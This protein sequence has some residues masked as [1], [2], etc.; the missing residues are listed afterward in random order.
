MITHIETDFIPGAAP[1]LLFDG[2]SPS[3]VALEAGVS[4]GEADAMIAAAW[5][6]VEAFTGRAYRPITAG[7]VIIRVSSPIAY[8]WPRHPFPEALTIEVLSNGTWVP[9]WETYVPAA[10]LVELEIYTL[11]RLTQVGTVT[12]PAP[13][14]HVFQAVINLALYQLIH[15]PA[16]REF[17]AQSAGDS[18]FTREALMGVMYGSGA[19]ALLASEMRL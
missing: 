11:Y 12:P 4:G 10:G 5:A 7:K 13:P 8:Q 6:Q 19:G 2:P 15:A 14:A 9:H 1:A 17:R 3:D 18:S 16:R